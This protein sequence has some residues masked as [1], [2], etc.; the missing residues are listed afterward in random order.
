[1]LRVVPTQ[2]RLVADDAAGGEIVLRLVV[3]L[4]IAPLECGEKLRLD[5]AA[6]IGHLT[7]FR[8]VHR[9]VAVAA[10]PGMLERQI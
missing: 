4:E 8:L 5:P 9:P 6:E 3:E 10:E 1:M 7:H 2:E